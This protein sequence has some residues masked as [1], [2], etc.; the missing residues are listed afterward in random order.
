M[1]SR[2]V[3]PG[4]DPALAKAFERR[5]GS[6]RGCREDAALRVTR[7]TALRLNAESRAQSAAVK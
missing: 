4:P 3:R 7:N 5:F 6:R 2:R 1:R